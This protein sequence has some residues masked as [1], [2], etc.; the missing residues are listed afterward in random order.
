MKFVFKIIRLKKGPY[1]VKGFEV[2]RCVALVIQYLG[3]DTELD[4][5]WIAVKIDMEI[6]D[7]LVYLPV[8]ELDKEN[9][10]K[11]IEGMRPDQQQEIVDG[12]NN[13]D[14]WFENSK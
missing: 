9:M 6:K 3:V 4:D 2:P 11:R 13:G 7:N 10:E 8:H 1:K 14:F 12:C 5:N